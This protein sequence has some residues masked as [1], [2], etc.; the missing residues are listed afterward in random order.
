MNT[1][2]K[3]WLMAIGGCVA[4]LAVGAAFDGPSD[5]DMDQMT[6]ADLVAAHHAERIAMDRLSKCQAT[7]GPRA[8]VVL[9]GI[10]GQDFVCRVRDGV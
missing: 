7:R 9:A 5:A 10:N 6:A 1:T 3:N 8:E 4:I 2:L